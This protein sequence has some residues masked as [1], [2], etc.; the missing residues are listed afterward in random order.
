VK[1][2]KHVAYPTREAAGVVWTYM[3]PPY[4]MPEFEAPAF[5]PTPDSKVAI[6]KVIVP[7][8]WA[9]ILEG[10]IDSAHSSSL[11]STDIPPGSND[12]TTAAGGV[13]ARPTSDKSPRIHVQRT[14]YG[15]RYAAIRRP[16]NDP[17]TKD[18]VRITTF[19]APNAV[20]I[21]PNNLYS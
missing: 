4:R 18:Y 5:A 1:Q 15:F 8:N 19:V 21:P 9:Q 14:S 10:A 6:V 13:W 7:C 20:L 12:Q 2:V 3:G 11:H 17:A 16:I